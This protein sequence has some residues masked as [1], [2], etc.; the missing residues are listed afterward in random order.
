[1][2]IAP[3]PNP[4]KYIHSLSTP[5]DVACA[6][7]AKPAESNRQDSTSNSLW[8]YRSATGPN[9]REPVMI[10]IGK[11]ANNAPD[12][13]S[14]NSNL[15]RSAGVTEPSVMKETP[16]SSIPAQAA[17]NTSDLL[18]VRSIGSFIFRF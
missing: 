13:S 15:F 10:P 2:L 7:P 9:S 18:Y 11:M 3:P 4:K 12:S 6:I 1:P 5:V 17:Q 16:K 14:D 8:P